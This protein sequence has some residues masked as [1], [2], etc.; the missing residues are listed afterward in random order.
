MRVPRSPTRRPKARRACRRTTPLWPNLKVQPAGYRTV[1]ATEV[2]RAGV[3]ATSWGSGFVIYDIIQ[4]ESNL[5]A[6]AVRESLSTKEA[7]FVALEPLEKERWASEYAPRSV[8]VVRPQDRLRAYRPRCW[9]NKPVYAL[10]ERSRR[11][12]QG[13]QER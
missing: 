7:A 13:S 4:A 10:H 11:R 12:A 8:Q 1:A 9:Q 6:H 2:V 3:L 5:A